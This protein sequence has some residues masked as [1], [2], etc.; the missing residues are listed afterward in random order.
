MGT[1]IAEH[2]SY[3]HGFDP[4]YAGASPAGPGSSVPSMSS[5]RAV[6]VPFAPEET[7]VKRRDSPG[8]ASSAGPAYNPN[9]D[10]L[11]ASGVQAFRGYAAD[12]DGQGGFPSLSLRPAG[13]SVVQ[14]EPEP[15][16]EPVPPTPPPRLKKRRLGFSLDV[17]DLDTRSVFLGFALA[18]LAYFVLRGV[19][20]PR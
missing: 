1:R 13:S 3:A 16:P 20:A 6:Q 15:E 10:Q 19:R 9:V 17:S 4:Y 11:A 18:V 2:D 12:H 8:G 14:S 7:S 5:Q